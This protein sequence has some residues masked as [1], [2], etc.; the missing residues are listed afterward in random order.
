MTHDSWEMH[1]CTQM[2]PNWPADVERVAEAKNF[3]AKNFEATLSKRLFPG[4][5]VQKLIFQTAGASQERNCNSLVA[6]PFQFQTFESKA[7]SSPSKVL[8]LTSEPIDTTKLQ[9][10]ISIKKLILR[11]SKLV[12]T[13]LARLGETLWLQ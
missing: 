9:K 12:M 7:K 6:K 1:K 11:S 4:E 3:E 2:N 13:E 5:L 10:N 8:W